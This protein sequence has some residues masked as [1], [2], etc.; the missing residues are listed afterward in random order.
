M[1][2]GVWEIIP[3]LID[4]SVVTSK[5]IYKIKHVIYGSIDKYK[6]RFVAGVFC[7]NEG[8]DYE[9]TIS[10][11]T[12]YTTIRSLVSLV[13]TMGWNIHQMDV[14]TAFQNGTIDEEVYIKQPKRFEVNSKDS[15]VCR[16][17]K[18]LY[19]LKQAPRPWYARMDAYL[20]RIGFV[21]SIVDPNLYIKVMNNKP[22]IIIQYVDDLLI[23]GV[24]RIIQ[25]CKKMLAAEFGMN[26]LG[27]MHYYLGLEVW[28][29]LGEIYL[30]QAAKHI[31]RY[32]RGTIHHRLKY[33]SKEVKLIGF[34]DFDWGGSETDGRSTT[35]GCFS[36][37]AAMISWMS[38]KKNIVALS[39]AK[40]EYVVACEVGKE[41][42]WLRNL[43]T[44]L[45]E[46]SLGPIM[47]N[48]ENQSCIKMSGDI[49]FHSST[50]HINNKFHFIRKLVQ[51]GTLKLEYVLTDEH[52]KNILTKALPN[53]KFEYLTNL[54][55]LVDIGDCIDDKE[56][57]DIC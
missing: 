44:D 19:G 26:D 47:I 46:E 3:R 16:L 39:S 51:D 43:L 13:A 37:G 32:L 21:K 28:Q 1:K 10:L 52:V 57:E 6:A 48:C 9:E 29:R 50:K 22:I 38:R 55:G 8:I 36:L 35:G 7:Q 34:T 42:A 15:H 53:K 11:T 31:L 20:L 56:M 12:R 18:A 27:L 54:M 14:K 23:T 24:E 5:W 45:F 33:D 4:K 25:E 40:A 41:V 49:V 2:N 30:R 17:K